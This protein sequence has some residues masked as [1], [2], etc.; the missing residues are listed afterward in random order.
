[1]YRRDYSIET[2]AVC[3]LFEQRQI[4]DQFN[5]LKII[6]EKKNS[7]EI[8]SFSLCKSYYNTKTK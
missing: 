6:T 4:K 2:L 1:M 8:E 3:L 7:S 5:C